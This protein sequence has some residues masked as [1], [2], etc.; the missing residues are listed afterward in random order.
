M[1]PASSAGCW[2]AASRRQ[3]GDGAWVDGIISD[4]SERKYNEMRI[5]ALLAE[6]G[7]MLD[8]VMFGILH[9]RERAWSRPTAAST[10]CSATAKG[11]L[12][13]DSLAVLFPTGNTT[14]AAKRLACPVLTAGSEFTGELQFRRRDGSLFWC[15]VSGRML[16]P[17]RPDEGSIWVFADVSE[18]RAGRGKAAPVRHRAGAHRRRRDGDRPARQ[19]RR[20]QSGLH[21][22]TGYAESRCAGHLVRPGAPR[23]RG[24]CGLRAGLARPRGNRLLARRVWSTRKDGEAYLEWLTVSAVRDGEDTVSHYVCVFSDITKLKESQDK[25]DHLAHHDRSPACRTA[26]C[27]TTACSMRWRA[28]PGPGAS[29]P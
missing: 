25:L 3:G 26:C 5:E 12:V 6:Q 24:R 9:V 16:D 11:A 23:P 29:W 14:S 7:A 15:M 20:R 27:S 28:R 2:K 4:I 19:D 17:E 10:P 1:R 22:I 18:R 21:P 13:G 8:N